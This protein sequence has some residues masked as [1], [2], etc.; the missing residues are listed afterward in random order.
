MMLLVAF[1]IMGLILCGLGAYGLMGRVVVARFREIGI[2]MA[3]GADRVGLAR[4]VMGSAL[5]P[6]I[7]GGLV[8]IVTAFGLVRLVRS[9]LFEVSPGDPVSFLVSSAFVLLVG[10]IAAL[11]PTLRALSIDPASTLRDD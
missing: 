1:G 2:R 11:V 8:G 7:V 3:L 6:M 4:S 10:V 5:R 9:L